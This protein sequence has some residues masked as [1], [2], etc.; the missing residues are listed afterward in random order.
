MVI[1]PHLLKNPFI[2]SLNKSRHCQ[3]ILIAW[4]E[5]LYQF[6]DVSESWNADEGD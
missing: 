5:G 4:P 2:L 6:L 1:F 3:P